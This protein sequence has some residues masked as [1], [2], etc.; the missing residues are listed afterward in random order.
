MLNR[1]AEKDRAAESTTTAWLD[2]Q[3]VARVEVTS[4]DVG[5]RIETAFLPNAE[6]GWRAGQPGEQTVRLVFDV[7]HRIRRIQLVFV[8]ERVERL[9]EFDL[10][11]LAE[12]A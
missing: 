2:L 9:Q 11:W 6:P 7:P 12:T 1:I 5:F 3:K 8:E 10:R 4:E